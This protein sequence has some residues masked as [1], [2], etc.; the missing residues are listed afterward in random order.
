MSIS[1]CEGT[2]NGRYGRPCD[3]RTVDSVVVQ[4]AS[5]KSTH[6]LFVKREMVGFKRAETSVCSS[7]AILDLPRRI[8]RDVPRYSGRIFSHSR[9]LNVGN[10]DLGCESTVDR[11]DRA[12]ARSNTVNLVMIHG[13]GLQA[14]QVLSVGRQVIGFKR[15]GAS[16]CSGG[17]IL[18]LAS[19]SWG[20][21]PRDSGRSNSNIANLNVRY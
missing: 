6:V 1:C 5:L 15:R 3:I 11:W 4:S 14:A 7:F 17:P 2:I 12:A 20:D 9:N 16:I 10:C 8:G 18:H 19:R 13:P 21:V